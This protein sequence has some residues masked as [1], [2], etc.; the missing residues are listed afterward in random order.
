M[1]VF[2]QKWQVGTKQDVTSIATIFRPQTIVG[3]MQ[4]TST[5]ITRFIPARDLH[6]RTHCANSLYLFFTVKATYL[7]PGKF[8][9]S[10][11]LSNIPLFPLSL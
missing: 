5:L 11:R 3:G 1:A 9:N 6:S 8:V 10:G 4:K 7:H 2:D